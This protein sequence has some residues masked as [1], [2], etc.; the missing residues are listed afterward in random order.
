[1]LNAHSH[2]H[3]PRIQPS[4]SIARHVLWKV[5]LLCLAILLLGALLLLSESRIAALVAV[6]READSANTGQPS[7]TLPDL[8]S[9]EA[10]QQM[11]PF[12]AQDGYLQSHSGMR[13]WDTSAPA[14]DDQVRTW[15]LALQADE[16]EP[17]HAEALAALTDAPPVIVPTLIDLL[18]DPDPGVRRWAAQILGARHAPEAQDSLFFAT[19]DLDSGVRATAVW[20]LGELDAIITLPRLEQMQVTKTESHVSEAASLAEKKLYAR[21]ANSLNVPADDL[22][23]VA[24]APSNGRVYAATVSDLYGPQDLGWKLISHLPDQATA[25]AT[26]GDGQVIYLGTASRGPFRSRDG[27]QTWEPIGK[28]L[29]VDAP[30]SVT[31][32]AVYPDNAQEVYLTLGTI[33]GATQE[34]VTPFGFFQTTDGGDTWSPVLQWNMDYATTRLVIDPTTPQYLYG[35]TEMGVWQYPLRQDIQSEPVESWR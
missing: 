31:A 23:A 29:S 5:L 19:F 12:I 13:Y 33:H 30:Y 17:K 16:A 32:L 8:N 34:P 24:I 10:K 18:S 3:T 22:R 27:G 4:L 14:S 9:A 2:F 11:V 7:S 21:I 20:A 25:L 35:L 28:G 1:M 26:A 6:F 15:L